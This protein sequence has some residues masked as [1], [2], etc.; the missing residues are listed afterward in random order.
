[1]SDSGFIGPLTAYNK[2]TIA[3]YARRSAAAALVR[4]PKKLNKRQIREVKRI[5]GNKQEK[6]YVDVLV[7]NATTSF[8]PGI[9]S[10]TTIPIGDDENTRDGDSVS[11]TGSID[12]RL[13]LV[14]ALGATGDSYNTYRFIVFQWKQMV[15]GTPSASEILKNGPSGAID[16]FSLYVDNEAGAIN[17]IYDKL[18][19]TTGSGS[20]GSYPVNSN[21]IVNKHIKLSTKRI[22]KKVVFTTSLGTTGMNKIF[23]LLVSDSDAATHPTYTLASRVYYTDS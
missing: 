16:P 7:D 22:R 19:S 20:S 3:R 6:K 10:L 11:L 8:A 4:K 17:V 15:A 23:Y 2:R 18:F 5:V 14:N 21:V 12:I 13:Q 9:A 1:M